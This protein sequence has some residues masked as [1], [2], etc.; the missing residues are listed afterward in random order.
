MLKVLPCLPSNS[1]GHLKELDLLNED[2]NVYNLIGPV[3]VKQDVAVAKAN[4]K[5]TPTSVSEL[6]TSLHN[7][8]FFSNLGTLIV[9]YL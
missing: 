6:I 9:V 2:A 8:L 7:C 1:G 3:L 5:A 4:A